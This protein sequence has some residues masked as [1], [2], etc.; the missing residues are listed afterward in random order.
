MNISRICGFAASL[1]LVSVSAVPQQ[2]PTRPRIFGIA[3]VEILSSKTPAAREFYSLV[4]EAPHIACEWCERIPSEAF[5]VNRAQYVGIASAQSPSP[6]SLLGEITFY[7]DDIAALQQYLK[8]NKIAFNA[9]KSGSRTQLIML[10]PEGH[11]VTFLQWSKDPHATP[12]AFGS[13]KQLIHA[14]FVVHDRD[15]EDKFYKD[16]LGFHLYWHGG[17]KD[18]TDDW[19]DM[20]V[21]DGSEWI[22][23]MLNVPA[24]ATQ[25]TRGVMNHIAIGVP[26]IHAEYQ[27]LV[28]N[29]WNPTEQPKIGRDG[30]WQLNL[31]DPDST[32]VEFMEFTPTDKPCCSP[33]VGPHPGPAQPN[34]PGNINISRL[35]DQQPG[36][37]AQPQL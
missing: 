10:D 11:K 22:E 27:H 16:L 15:A 33:Y 23:Y 9:D 37:S 26:D 14:G 8:F 6:S 35:L 12:P 3:N 30:K 17:M 13:E 25:L 21:P 19:V 20:Q 31:Y 28:A 5:S 24:N 18:G 36:A 1:L 29:G 7:T 34:A 32:R 2:T 4:L